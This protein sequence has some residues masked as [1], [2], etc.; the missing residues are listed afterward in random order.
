MICKNIHIIHL[1]M[2][3]YIQYLYSLK[4]QNCKISTWNANKSCIMEHFNGQQLPFTNVEMLNIDFF[5]LFI[6]NFTHFKSTKYTWIYNSRYK[7][8][9]WKWKIILDT[10]KRCEKLSFYKKKTFNVCLKNFMM[11]TAHWKVNLSIKFFIVTLLSTRQTSVKMS[12]MMK[13]KFY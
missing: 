10:L 9:K 8:W 13:M 6:S 2:K 3:Y 5:K 12:L 1:L 4:F 11:S 7:I